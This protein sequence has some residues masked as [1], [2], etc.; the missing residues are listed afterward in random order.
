MNSENVEPM[1]PAVPELSPLA[2]FGV[3]SFASDGIVSVPS[4][5]PLDE[6]AQLM[7]NRGVHAVVVVDDSREP[8]VIS[9]VDLI[10]AAASGHFDRLS[11][12]DIAGTESI[13]ID[14]DETLNRAA[15]ILT[16]HGVA[17]LIVRDERRVPVGVLS[18]LDLARAISGRP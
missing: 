15:Q 18:T 11:A 3:N 10:A 8:P 9:D 2:G 14:R 5:A 7:S 1:S 6:V 12:G 16:E 4:D 13:S 17:H